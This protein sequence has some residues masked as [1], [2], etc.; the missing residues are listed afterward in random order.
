MFY[1]II[2]ILFVFLFVIMSQKS[3]STKEEKK[4]VQV[5]VRV[6]PINNAEK[7]ARSYTVVGCNGSKEIVVKERPTDRLT[8]TFTF[9][10]VFGPESKQVDVYKSV[11]HPL[12]DEV[13]AGYNCTVFAY[14]QT[15]TGKT[16]TMEGEKTND[17]TIS[18]ENDPLSGIIPRSLS[19]LFDE[20]RLINAEYTVRVSFL[21][22]Y[23]EEIFDLLSPPDDTTKLK[24]FE[25][26]T[27]K[28]SVIIQG[29]EEV[30]VHNK[31]EVYKI[32]EKGSAKRTTAATLMNAQSSRS[33]T[34]FSITVHIKENSIDGEELLKT[35]KLNLVDLAGSENISR[36][37]AVDKRAREAGNIN[38][39]L[40][41]LGR[42][43]TS[44]VE[45]C[46]HIP[47]RES[48]LTRLLQESL[49][50]RTKTSIIATVSPAISNLEETLSTLDYAHRAKNITNKPEINQKLTKAALLK[51]YTTEIERLRRD[52][53][54]LREKNGIIL[55]PENYAQIMMDIEQ[56][57]DELANK[58]SQLKAMEEKHDK[59]EELT[60]ML[61]TKLNETKD[62][63]RKTVAEKEEK[64]FLV[65]KYMEREQKFKE[66]N[67]L[68]RA[69][70]QESTTDV[71]KLHQKLEIKKKIEESNLN[72]INLFSRNFHN[73]NVEV[74]HLIE[75][76][77][78]ESD[79]LVELEKSLGGF[80]ETQTGSYDSIRLS[81]NELDSPQRKLTQMVD[82]M[83]NQMNDLRDSQK[84]QHLTDMNFVNSTESE[85]N[86]IDETLMEPFKTQSDQ[87]TVLRSNQNESLSNLLQHTNRLDEL[88]KS[89]DFHG[90]LGNIQT[91]LVG[92]SETL[93]KRFDTIEVLEGNVHENH[94]QKDEEMVKGIELLQNEM[95]SLQ[96]EVVSWQNKIQNK[97]TSMQSMMDKLLQ[98]ANKKAAETQRN[99]LLSN[100]R[101][102]AE[103]VKDIVDASHL[104]AGVIT[105]HED[106]SNKIQ[107]L[108]ENIKTEIKCGS[109]KLN[110]D[111]E[112]CSSANEKTK[113]IW[114]DFTDK[115]KTSLGSYKITVE[116]SNQDQCSKFEKLSGELDSSVEP[117]QQ[118]LTTQKTHIIN[119]VDNSS[120][121][122]VQFTNSTCEQLEKERNKINEQLD[123]ISRSVSRQTK[124]VDSFVN[125][126]VKKDLPTGQTPERRHWQFPQELACMS[127]HERLIQRFRK[128]RPYDSF[129]SDYES[130]GTGDRDAEDDKTSEEDSSSQNSSPNENNGI[131]KCESSSDILNGLN[132][133]MDSSTHSDCNSSVI[134]SI[135]KKK[136][137]PKK[138]KAKALFKK[139]LLR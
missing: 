99:D 109:D 41:T 58:I 127:P 48:K 14:G 9:D 71:E 130:N 78:E 12:I 4:N 52:I 70:V 134:S 118:D 63:L 55:A 5:F 88:Q 131:R 62:K 104:I 47:Y 72:A 40:L 1:V 2:Y 105:E 7:A 123:S 89:S 13:L 137:I 27:R 132:N 98:T 114:K 136:G 111:V 33:H 116:T 103:N 61:D 35:G 110:E 25:D 120:S 51:E 97:M 100:I 56:K 94:L 37:G 121:N 42:C 60:N 34:V 92:Q 87:L 124:L 24:L 45:H 26:N 86:N 38:Q 54:A 8:K 139:P 84:N 10:K 133:T 64:N 128:E 107:S 22:L 73:D 16:F 30:T 83:K 32:L 11:V 15:G 28:G 76:C 46:P 19:H 68:L 82:N 96:T 112:K 50:G 49:G 91:T 53:E 21:E 106:H 90:R 6:R 67:H 135:S 138:N 75:E 79:F 85:Y 3:K 29:L 39:S 122:H 81:A 74:N 95:V 36:S 44:L 117:I 101:Q 119:T 66:Q 18:W 126:E 93:Q 115:L 65:E 31:Q 102:G 113:N 20:L 108:N 69:T 23:N 80:L 17:S 129:D 59:L 43:I 57:D 77:R 125:Q